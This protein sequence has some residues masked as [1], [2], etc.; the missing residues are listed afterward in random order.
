MIGWIDKPKRWIVG[1]KKNIKIDG[2]LEGQK[3][4]IDVQMDRKKWKDDWMEEK[5]MKKDMFG[6]I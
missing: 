3:K 5:D 1:R 4:Q 2:W 6:W